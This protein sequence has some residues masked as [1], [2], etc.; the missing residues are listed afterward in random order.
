MSSSST[1]G[2]AP[3]TFDQFW[4][5]L[6]DHR[7]CLVR[8]GSGEVALFDNDFVHWDFFD[9]EDGRAVCQ[10]ILGKS[11]LGELVIER[12]DVLFVQS[13]LDVED[14]S[15]GYHL[16]ECVGGAGKDNFP[17]YHFV[18]THGMDTPQGHQA[19]KH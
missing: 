4:R 17:L 5:W 13:S 19:L 8:A 6:Q 9:E 7:N 15:Q 1:T 14:P 16:F 2:T 3:L 10:V 18:L 11:L 12:A